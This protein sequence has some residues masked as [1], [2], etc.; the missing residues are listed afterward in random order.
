MGVAQ[1]AQDLALN[2]STCFNL[3]RT[4]VHERLVVFDPASKWGVDGLIRL[5]PPNLPRLSEVR[6]DG[7]VLAFTLGV[8]LAASMVFGL[9]PAIQAGRVDLND[10]LKQ[11]GARSGIGGTAG[12]SA[13]RW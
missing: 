9:V 12:R 4:L 7:W 11:G 1:V 13:R 3:L 6:V 10:A 8:S 2:A 5:A